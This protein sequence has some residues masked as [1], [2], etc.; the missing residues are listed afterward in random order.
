MSQG[1][2]S[3]I[4][5]R[6]MIDSLASANDMRS[7]IKAKEYVDKKKRAQYSSINVGDYVLVQQDKTGK[8]S[9]NFDHRPYK[10]I[11]KEGCIVNVEREGKVLKRS[12][13]HCKLVPNYRTAE[14]D[15]DET[16]DESIDLENHDCIVDEPNRR[17]P[18][19]NR[20]PPQ[21]YESLYT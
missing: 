14:Q 6:T 5:D 13:G 21:R 17:Y 15:T 7:K 16:D 2:L 12:T 10:V 1:L 20:R 19:R 4:V 11:H 9:T 3:T 8:L 18:I